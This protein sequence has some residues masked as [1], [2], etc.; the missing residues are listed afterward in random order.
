MAGFRVLWANEFIKEA[1]DVYKANSSQKTYLDDRDI[2]DINA[3]EILERVGLERGEID[4]LDG[5]PPCSSFSPVGKLEEGWGK[6][7]KY[8][9]SKQRTDDLF[10]EFARVLKG[11]QPKTFVAENVKGLIT[12]SAKGYFIQILTALRASGYV[13][14]CRLLNASFLG[15]PQRRQR[16]I[17][18]GVRNDIANRY[19]LKPAYPKPLPYSY[20][21]RDA[22]PWIM[23]SRNDSG[24]YCEPVTINPEAE[25]K[26]G[27]CM[28]REYEKLSSYEVHSEKYFQLV[29]SNPDK[30]AYTVIAGSRGSS[31]PIQ[32]RSF[33][34]DE[35]IRICSFPDDFALSGS[36]SQRWERLGRSV[37][38]VMM[39]QIS[40][41]IRDN[42]LKPEKSKCAE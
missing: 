16:V 41:A 23:N 31:H 40:A 37:P 14:E 17:F 3:D 8:S 26:T 4:L 29:K 1:R 35:V 18:V 32:P 39:M 36:Y 33:Y 34:I 12:G 6:V 24:D 19:N 13:V 28:R 9:E 42:I 21:L 11:T 30:P 15:V 25:Y 2:R 38:P 7:K 10:F 20:S 22:C 5:S 27:S